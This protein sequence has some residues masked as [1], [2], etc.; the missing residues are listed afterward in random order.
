M[1]NIFFKNKT[2]YTNELNPIQGYLDQLTHYI[3]YKKNIPKE[4]AEELSKIIFRE[5]FKDRNIKYFEREENGD[6]V[7]KDGNLYR[8]IKDN[9]DNK[10]ILVPTFTS[11]L[12]SNVKQSIL[13]EFIFVNVKKRSIAKKTSQQ[14][15][16]EGN[17]ELYISKNNE[18]NTM[19]IYNNSLSGV[20]GQEACILYNPTAH[21]TLTT[22][23]RTITSLSNASN[24]KMIAGNRYY[25]RP[26]DIL[27]NIIYISTYTDTN[28]V[29]ETIEKFNL[30]IPTIEDTVSILKYSSDLYFYD[31][32]YYED[33][34]IPYLEKLTPYHLASICYTGDLYHIRKFNETFIRNLLEDFIIPSKLDP[35]KLDDP[36][37]IYKLDES[38]LYF[39]HSILFSKVKG[40]GKDY[41][42][43]NE[44]NIASQVYDTYN[45]VTET[46]KK[47]KL[48]FNTFF[49]T[50][51]MP[52]NSH[53]LNYF[54]RK[55]VVLSDTDSTCF[56]MDEWITWY[57]G[58]Y[59]V[60]DRSIALSGLITY[61]ASQSIV[62]T[63][64][65]VSK[66]MNIKE[67]LLNTLA[68]KSEFLWQSF[69]PTSVSKHYFAQTIMQE[70]N[71]FKTPETEIKGVHLRNSAVPKLSID[72]GNKLMNY[73]L[74]SIKDNKKVSLNYVLSE[75]INMELGI[76]ESVKKG[77]TIYLKKSKIKSKE[78]YSLDEFK[79]PYQRHQL[80]VDVFE[81]KYGNI[82]DPPYDVVKIPTTITSKPLLIEWIDG[83]TD[84]ELKE[85]LTVW[86]ERYSKK[87][88][89]TLY[90]NETY[91]KGNGIPEEIINIIDIKRV[92]FDMTI[93]HRLILE[94]LGVL[95]NDEKM[96]HEQFVI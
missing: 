32:K 82:E 4:K 76:I 50:E 94:T 54:K 48:F 5:Y 6:R 51:I 27:N 3:E 20:F 71:V 55:T 40:Y 11:Y 18:Q 1:E 28:K 67:D 37:I 30:Y 44:D 80:W 96:I 60:D 47:Y 41:I 25:P 90:L 16:A 36:S 77:E 24:E 79:S 22:I 66:N 56:T 9:L 93:Q 83:I 87:D 65:I 69:I 23:T 57:K 43:M 13:S 62:N 86:L 26:I 68:M 35:R 42:K 34:I 89:P 59:F 52:S 75:I 33:K 85:R 74:D 8:Y 29:K 61:I 72:N 46:L 88:L 38:I 49:M 95:I 64:A 53:R 91:V 14:A 81:Q 19:K 92:V 39:T 73:I 10:N 17:T 63:L 58:H 7:V 31:K 21:S 45:I 70:G 78:A 84:Y 12:N 15:K 2:N